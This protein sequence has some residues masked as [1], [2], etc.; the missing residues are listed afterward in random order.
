R[1]SAQYFKSTGD[2]KYLAIFPSEG[3]TDYHDA[4]AEAVMG[5]PV[6]GVPDEHEARNLAL[7]YLPALGI[8]RD[9]LAVRPGTSEIDTYGAK[10]TRTYHDKATGKEI[11]AHDFRGVYFARRIDG[12]SIEGIGLDGGV[13]ISFGNN[14]KISDLQVVWRALKPVEL[15]TTLSPENVLQKLRNGEIK[16]PAF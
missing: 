16:L 14:S 12:V 11:T 3:W 8:D 9:H 1:K 2:S 10:G 6:E 5:Q 4:K 15:R 7:Q 13:H